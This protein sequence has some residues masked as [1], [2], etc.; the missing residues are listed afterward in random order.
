MR[1]K[2]ASPPRHCN[3]LTPCE[4][5]EQAISPREPWSDNGFNRLYSEIKIYTMRYNKD[6]IAEMLAETARAT[7]EETRRVDAHGGGART[8][9]GSMQ[10]RNL[11]EISR[12]QAAAERLR[13]QNQIKPSIPGAVIVWLILLFIFPAATPATLSLPTAGS[14]VQNA[15]PAILL[16]IAASR[17][18]S[19]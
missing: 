19:T 8:G 2:Q 9:L 15:Y 12:E 6:F 4:S 13:D 3:H 17:P 14:H 7:S 10:P 11:R 18:A 16:T 5:S 1:M